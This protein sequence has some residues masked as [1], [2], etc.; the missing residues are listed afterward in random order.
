MTHAQ[1]DKAAVNNSCPHLP[2]ASVSGELIVIR[3]VMNSTHL[4]RRARD[5]KIVS[6]GKLRLRPLPA[7]LYGGTGGLRM[8]ALRPR[9]FV[10]LLGLAQCCYAP[11]AAGP[12]RRGAGIDLPYPRSAVPTGQAGPI[13]VI[14]QA[15][16]SS[17]A[18]QATL[19]TLQGVIARHSPRIY[20]IKSAS[21][22]LQPN[23]VDSDT[24][25][26]WL[27]DLEAHHGLTF[28]YTHLNDL[29]SLI[30]L[31]SSNITGFAAYD[32]ATGST[33]AAL[34]RCAASDG[35][36]SAGTPTMVAHLRSLGIPMVANLTGSTPAEEF[37]RAKTKL[38][39]RGMVSQ[40]DDGSKSQC[41]SDYA[42]FARLP[43]I[44]HDPSKHG[45]KDGDGFLA[46][47]DHFD[48]TKLSAAYGWTTDEHQFTAAVTKAGGVVH[49]SDFA[50]NLA[51][52]SQ[53]PPY[54]STS[55]A[56][57]SR[58]AARETE[59]PQRRRSTGVHT[60]A[61]VM[62]DGDN[63]QILQND[64]MS[65]RHWSHPQRGSYPT[66][67]SYSPAMAQLMPSMLA[68]VARTATAN[69][70]L[71]TGPSGVGYAYPQLYT[72]TSREI[73]AQATNQLMAEARMSVVNVIGVTPSEQSVAVIAAQPEV[74]G[75]IYFTFGVADQGY[76]GLHGNV[77][78]TNGKPVVG[79]RSCLWGDGKSG[80]KVGVEGLIR[81]LHALPKDPSNPQSY[82]II[83]NEMG[84]GWDSIRNASQILMEDGGFVRCERVVV[85][86]LLIETIGLRQL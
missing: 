22:K 37:A 39:R 80:D 47:L 6:R 74:D 51:L 69:D 77:A 55:P 19:G 75:I 41:L 78:Y 21:P 30:A 7:P 40:P 32:Q 9:A 31:F 13:F 4:D 48:K 73:F 1:T 54:K 23:S 45:G 8:A 17:T 20:T 15:S 2:V 76:A 52:F 59:Q 34:T 66:S 72:P 57:A 10:A 26:F 14:S 42:V 5:F 70:S 82:S 28:D 58:S 86:R 16:I 36:I 24:T 56:E 71:T 53:L 84:N 38:S 61:F 64:F 33:N 68:Y 43:T 3:D 27:H 44:E 63:L 81:D 12:A 25:V 65:S 85:L 67:W 50:Y 60:V 35:V 83:V 46:V 79:L 62:S 18:D 29:P 11:A 49:A